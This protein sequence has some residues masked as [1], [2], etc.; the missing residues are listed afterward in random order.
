MRNWLLVLLGCCSFTPSFA[1]PKVLKL[2][3]S[4]LNADLRFVPAP[5]LYRSPETSWGLG[6][7]MGYYFK[8]DKG[9][10]T[11]NLQFQAVRTFN[12]QTLLRLA[13]DIFTKEERIFIH[14]YTGYK[15]YLDRF[16]GIGPNSDESNREDFTFNSWVTAISVLG[17]VA[18]DAFIGVN[19]RHQAMYNI[20]PFTADATIGTLIVPGGTG[21]TTLGFGPEFRLDT[22]DNVMSPQEGGLIDAAIRFHPSYNALNP[23]FQT[24]QLDIRHYMPVGKKHVWANRIFN[25]HQ[26]GEPPFRELS[27]AGGSELVRGYFQGRY[28]DKSLS[29]VETEMRFHLWKMIGVTVFTSTFQVGPNPASI[30]QNRWKGAYG[31]GFRFFVNQKERIVLRID[32]ARTFEGHTAFYLN[33]NESF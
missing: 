20:K 11:S 26:E 12:Q 13:A 30:L 19:L 27:L 29:A 25:Q 4:L 7:S 33:L 9:A 23:A 5:I 10:R 2:V 16:Y 28:R 24:Y 15:K 3:D 22:R 1:Q 31:A 17:K 32:L 18:P 8:T 6:A 14:Y 21:S